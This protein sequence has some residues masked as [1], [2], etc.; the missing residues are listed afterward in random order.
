VLVHDQPNHLLEP[1]ARVRRP[2]VHTLPK[3][4]LRP[5]YDAVYGAD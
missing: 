1:R 3:A 2:G 4:A 5:V